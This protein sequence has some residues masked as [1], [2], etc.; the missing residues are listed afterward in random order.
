[1]IKSR[2]AVMIAAAAILGIGAA[3]VA[4]RWAASQ[5]A[6]DQNTQPVVVAALE[7]P[8]GQKLDAAHV[9]IVP[10]PKA[11]LPAGTFDKIA[12]V[13]GKVT[14]QRLI[15][16]EPLLKERI[17]DSLAGSTLA[18][19]VDPTKRAI[20]VR[21][22]DVIGVAGFLLPGNRVDVLA[23]RKVQHDRAHTETVLENI[24]VL[25]VDQIAS[26]D[27]DK[28]VVVRAV[29]LEV[30][31]S[32][33]NLLVNATV[34][35]TV[36]LALRNPAAKNVEIAQKSRTPATPKPAAR[37]D[38]GMTFIRGSNVELTDRQL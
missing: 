8:F 11:S 5:L 16:G 35:G 20:T 21:V 12:E 28:P 3:V 37:S 38:S 32:Q 30:T 36:Q 26:P 15:P 33:A 10:W 27:K 23:S 29:T 7:I 13:E 24:R 22:N 4:S 25:A 31:P 19:M 2:T 6:G 18:A 34:E 14:N 1:M 17:V 9:K